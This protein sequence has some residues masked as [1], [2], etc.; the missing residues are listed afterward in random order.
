LEEFATVENLAERISVN[1]KDVSLVF[2]N[3]KRAAFD[4]ALSDG[5]RVAFVPP[6]GGM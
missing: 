5:D 1:K 2:V 6:T 4:T 3:G